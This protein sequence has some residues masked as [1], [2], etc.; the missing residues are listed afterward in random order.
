MSGVDQDANAGTTPVREAHRFDEE[1][2][3]RWMTAH[4]D[5]FSGPLTVEQFKGGQSNDPPL[6]PVAPRRALCPAPQ[7]AGAVAAGRA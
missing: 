7:A 4:V 5:G 2:L 1:A 3:A 6:S